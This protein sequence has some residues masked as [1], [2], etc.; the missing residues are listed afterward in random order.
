M[1]LSRLGKLYITV[2]Y[3]ITNALMI[4]VV[5]FVFTAAVMR[6]AGYPLAWSV[7]FGTLLF[8]WVIFLGANRA[9]RENRH[10]GVD[11][12]TQRMPDKLRSV[13]EI[14]MMVIM[15]GFLLF[16]FYYG[17]LLCIENSSRLISNLPLSY[18]WV[19]AAVPT[20]CLLMTITLIVKIRDKVRALAGKG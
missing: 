7:E 3:F 4:G 2:E 14:S 1:M 10:I 5:L 18:S 20:G 12:F 13:V 15:I 9:L 8:V 6:W 16:I 11:F 19:T 17:V